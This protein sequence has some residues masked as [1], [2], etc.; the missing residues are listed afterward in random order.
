M[1]IRIP[2]FHK[3]SL[4]LLDGSDHQNG[5]PTS[6][7]QKGFLLFNNDEDLAGEAVGFGVPVLKLG[8]QAIFPGAVE[9]DVQ[10]NASQWQIA[11]AY[12]MNLVEKIARRGKQDVENSQLYGIKNTLAAI[13]RRRPASRKILSGASGLIRKVFK[14]ETHYAKSTFS[15]DIVLRHTILEGSGEIAVRVDNRN[16]PAEVTEVAIMNELSAE[17]FDR[18]R[19]S[20]GVR[21]VGDK[22]G[23]WDEVQA[24]KAWFES[25]SR[26]LRFSLKNVAGAKLY[27]GMEMVAGRL[28]WAGFGY[29]LSPSLKNFQ[30]ELRL[31]EIG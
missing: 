23:C 27:R 28:A 9:L 15:T 12:R 20:S 16:L 18:Y 31:E 19:D 26:H 24:K 21:L 1:E 29:S 5:Y 6:T 25:S 8:L 7:L 2:L 22:I 4:R 30:Y 17:V 10:R 13:I 11:T 3:S 14:L